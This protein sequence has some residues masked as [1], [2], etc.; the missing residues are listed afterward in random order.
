MVIEASVAWMSTPFKDSKTKNWARRGHDFVKGSGEWERG[1]FEHV[2]HGRVIQKS[3]DPPT[4]RK[5]QKKRN[6]NRAKARSINIKFLASWG[7]PR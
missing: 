3:R 4:Q 1:R 2:A 5:I 6:P 7:P